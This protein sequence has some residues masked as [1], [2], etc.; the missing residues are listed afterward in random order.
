[1]GTLFL[2]ILKVFIEVKINFRFSQ[3]SC[4]RRWLHFLSF[5]AKF[6]KSTMGQVCNR[7]TPGKVDCR[8][9]N[10][11]CTNGLGYGRTLGPLMDFLMHHI[12]NLCT[13]SAWRTSLPTPVLCFVMLYYVMVCYALLSCA[14]LCYAMLCYAMLWYAMLCYAMLCY[15]MLCYAMLC[16]GV[17]ARVLALGKRPTYRK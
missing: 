3:V 8:K 7:Y 4:S 15:A 10:S 13:I 9:Q 6:K 16:C 14:M 12:L 5:L 1:M 11:F 2:K 17:I